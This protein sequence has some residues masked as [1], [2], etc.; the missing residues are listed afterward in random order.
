MFDDHLSLT[1]VGRVGQPSGQ[2]EWKA[3]AQF[4]HLRSGRGEQL[5]LGS[6]L[7]TG[8][9]AQLRPSWLGLSWPSVPEHR[10]Q[11]LHRNGQLEGLPCHPDRGD[12]CGFPLHLVISVLTPKLQLTWLRLLRSPSC[13]SVPSCLLPPAIFIPTHTTSSTW[14]FPPCHVP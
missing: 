10:P 13:P 1:P 7:P 11:P 12:W 14:A 8:G 5:A 6:H 2:K 4:C 9:S 3:Q